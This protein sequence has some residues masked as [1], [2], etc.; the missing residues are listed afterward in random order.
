M[1]GIRTGVLTETRYLIVEIRSALIAV[2]AVARNS[3]VHGS[4]G[5]SGK[6]AVHRV[7][8]ANQ[9]LSSENVLLLQHFPTWIRV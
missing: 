9:V 1:L 2:I 3:A 4:W 5:S 6:S 8:I 7:A